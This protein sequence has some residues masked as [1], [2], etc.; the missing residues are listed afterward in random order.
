MRGLLFAAFGAAG[1]LLVDLPALA[2]L[3]G[4]TSTFSGEVAA[5]CS[6]NLPDSLSMGYGGT[7]KSLSV[8]YG[9]NVTTNASVIRMSVDQ[10]TVINEPPPGASPIVPTVY[11]RY[12]DGNDA[13]L[14]YGS[15]TSGQVSAP[16]SVS[17]SDPNLF[18]IFGSVETSSMVDGKF[19]L[20]P[21][22]YSYST[23]ISCLL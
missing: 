22:N 18:N 20:P 2:Q 3:A 7:R 4:D 6:F 9:F 11:I 15:K 21:G 16:L 23:T 17:S 13:Y 10:L 12:S 14:V 8:G 1:S 5:S 19:Q